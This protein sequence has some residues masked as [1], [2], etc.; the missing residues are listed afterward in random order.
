MLLMTWVNVLVSGLIVGGVYALVS[1][2]LNLQ[3]GLMRVLN[4]AHG[5]FVMLGAFAGWWVC[6]A[7]GGNPAT[8]ALA[9]FVLMTALGLLL[10]WGVFRRIAAA[11]PS[12]EAFEGRSL[13]ACFGLMFIVQNAVVLV[14][15]GELRGFRWFDQPLQIGPL[16]LDANQVAASATAV[17]L[18]LGLMLVLRATMLGKAVRGLMQSPVGAELVGINPRWLHPV[19]FGI[20]LGLAGVAGSLLAMVYPISPAMG[21][22]YSITA[23][24]VIT[25]GGFG[26]VAGSLAGGLLLG[27]VEAIGVELTHPALRLVL[28]YGLFLTVMIARPRGLFSR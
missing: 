13:I 14:W 25:L 8:A 24:I 22:P 5:E 20:G 18:A 3:Y 12:V 11:A 15:G 6:T 26:S 1:V 28:A 27:V 19:V 7:L 9:V 16:Q 4:I 10:H 23:L 17:L 2:G 21:A